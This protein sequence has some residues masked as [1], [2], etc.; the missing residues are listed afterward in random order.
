MPCPEEPQLEADSRDQDF[1]VVTGS[2]HRI[3]LAIAK[4]LHRAS[5]KVARCGHP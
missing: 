5:A 1:A 3:G 2:V 4:R